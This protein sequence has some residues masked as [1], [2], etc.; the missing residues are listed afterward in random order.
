[1][2]E[3]SGKVSDGGEA[4]KASVESQRLAETAGIGDNLAN[5]LDAACTVAAL[6]INGRFEDLGSLLAAL[7]SLLEPVLAKLQAAAVS[8]VRALCPASQGGRTRGKT[9]AGR[10]GLQSSHHHQS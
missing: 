3:S 9:W 8:L 2:R 1:M 6:F 5:N 4:V 7:E 10:E